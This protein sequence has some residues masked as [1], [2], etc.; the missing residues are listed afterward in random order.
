MVR[1]LCGCPPYNYF[2]ISPKH[3]YS[4]RSHK[5]GNYDR[6]RYKSFPLLLVLPGEPDHK[7]IHCPMA[8]FGPLLRSSLTDLMLVT[9]FEI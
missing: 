3:I 5:Y 8:N 4:S 7:A 2:K 9:A 6:A 1:S